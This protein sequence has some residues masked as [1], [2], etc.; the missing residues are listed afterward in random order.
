MPALFRP[1]RATALSWG[2]RPVRTPSRFSGAGPD[3]VPGVAAHIVHGL[4]GVPVQN[5]G[6][7]FGVGVDLRKVAVAASADDV[8]HAVIV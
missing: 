2:G 3:E 8:G 4:F 1:L 5:G 7:L 6:G